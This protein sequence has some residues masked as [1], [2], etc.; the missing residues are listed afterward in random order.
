MINI[1]EYKITWTAENQ[2][3]GVYLVRFEMNGFTQMKKIMLVK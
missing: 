2:S 3:S 1:G